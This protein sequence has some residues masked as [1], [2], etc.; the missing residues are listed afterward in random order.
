M[1][2][3]LFLRV[4]LVSMKQYLGCQAVVL[5]QVCVHV[6]GIKVRLCSFLPDLFLRVSLLHENKYAA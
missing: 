1:S 6:L 4:L 3:A 2:P 5:P